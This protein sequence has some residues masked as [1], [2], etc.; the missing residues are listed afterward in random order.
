MAF[1]GSGTTRKL[2]QM[3]QIDL[4]AVPFDV[5]KRLTTSICIISVIYYLA[6]SIEISNKR[7]MAM[8]ILYCGNFTPTL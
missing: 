3:F 5:P 8:S 6:K 7:Q 4:L 1:K 2:Q